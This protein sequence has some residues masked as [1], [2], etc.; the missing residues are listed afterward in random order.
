MTRSGTLVTITALFALTLAGCVPITMP[1][2][3]TIDGQSWSA[4]FEVEVRPGGVAAI[5]LPVNLTLTFTQRLQDI[6]AEA[7]LQY[8][9]GIFVLQ[10]PGL[11]DLKGRL[12]FDD[13]L[14]LRSDSGVLAFEGT[15]LG[16]QLVGTVSIAGVV[17][18][19]SVVFT[20]GR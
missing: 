1:G 9:T 3:R 20:R 13:R 8:D 4:R 5:R 14:D 17:P 2:L 11:V 7:T 15:F 10:S 18:V 12:G 16:E 19:G 6:T